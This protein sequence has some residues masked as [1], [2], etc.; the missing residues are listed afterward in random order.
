MW[1]TGYVRSNSGRHW[2]KR[3]GKKRRGKGK[4]RYGKGKRREK[5]KREGR[6]RAVCVAEVVGP[7]RRPGEEAGCYSRSE[8]ERSSFL[9]SPLLLFFLP[10][11]TETSGMYE[12]QAGA[13]N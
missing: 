11:V 6:T 12:V 7:P 2:D 9:P 13:A 5:R 1:V 10:R 3:D 8:R 4:E